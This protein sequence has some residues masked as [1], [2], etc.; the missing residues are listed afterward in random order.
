MNNDG[1]VVAQYVGCELQKKPTQLDQARFE[2]V[3]AAHEIPRVTQATVNATPLCPDEGGG[4]LTG[5]TAAEELLSPVLPL[6]GSRAYLNREG[7]ELWINTITDPE[8][9][10]YLKDHVFGTDPLMPGAAIMELSCEGAMAYCSANGFRNVRVIGLRT[11]QINRGISFPRSA[12]RRLRLCA[13]QMPGATSEH[14]PSVIRVRIFS[15][16]M[17]RNGV[18]VRENVLHATGE[19]AIAMRHP[20]APHFD[21]ELPTGVEHFYLQKSKLYEL[22]I[23]THGPLLSSLTGRLSIYE[24]G[25][26]AI[27]Q[28]ELGGLEA[29]FVKECGDGFI[30]SPLSLDSAFQV[31]VWWCFMKQLG[32]RVPVGCKGLKVYSMPQSGK[33]YY[34]HIQNLRIEDSVSTVRINVFDNTGAIIFLIEECY[35]QKSNFKAWGTFQQRSDEDNIFNNYRVNKSI[36]SEK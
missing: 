27:G 17:N 21:M 28:F 24:G 3:L 4:V 33:Y 2:G 8:A 19:V 32:G 11:F 1:L 15:D 29:S 31:H 5:S 20:M 13:D 25:N 30:V 6:L 12:P 22:W 34:A 36:F 14:L 9:H 23:K 18:T 16:A 26:A 35:F 7:G 10:P